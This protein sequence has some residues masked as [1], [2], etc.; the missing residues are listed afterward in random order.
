MISAEETIAGLQDTL[1]LR[2]RIRSV[3]QLCG[4]GAVV[5]LI[6]TL[7]LT[8]DRLPARAQV[9]FAVV[10][11]AGLV[12]MVRAAY[13]LRSRGRLFARD[14]VVASW[15]ASGFAVLLALGLALAGRGALGVPVVL[16]ALLAVLF[17]YQ[18]KRRLERR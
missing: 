13:V 9:G 5:A 15:I 11:L 18:A 17:T 1:S 16:A 3:V 7:W 14:R 12:V 10:V 8:E 2:R 6:G 4:A